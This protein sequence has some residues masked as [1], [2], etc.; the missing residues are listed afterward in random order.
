MISCYNLYNSI[1]LTCCRASA[2]HEAAVSALLPACAIPACRQA[3]L[4][5]GQRV[6][7]IALAAVVHG[8]R[9]RGL[10]SDQSY[11]HTMVAGVQMDNDFQVASYIFS[12]ITSTYKCL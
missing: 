10:L 8:H 2:Q 12:D 6:T 5:S 9:D 7:S 4:Q 3:A 11:L 1:Y